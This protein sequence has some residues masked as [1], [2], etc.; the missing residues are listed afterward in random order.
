MLSEPLPPG[1]TDSAACAACHKDI[2]EAYR[3]TGMG[4]SFYRPGPR[5]HR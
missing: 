4:R 3:R 5:K 1:Y 2:A